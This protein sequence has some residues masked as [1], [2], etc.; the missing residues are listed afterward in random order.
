MWT[1]NKTLKVVVP[2]RIPSIGHIDLSKNYLYLIELCA[3]FLNMT[4]QKDI[5]MNACIYQSPLPL[6]GCDTRSVFKWS[7]RKKNK[8]TL[9]TIVPEDTKCLL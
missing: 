2:I 9:T 4:T 1:I 8:N 7:N 6:A 5:N 3:K